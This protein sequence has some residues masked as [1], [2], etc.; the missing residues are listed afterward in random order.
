MDLTLRPSTLEAL[1]TVRARHNSLL[2]WRGVLIALCFVLCLLAVIAL[3][4]RAWL[5]PEKA[6]PW[7]SLAAYASCFVAAW[8][9][10]LRYLR[11]ETDQTGIARHAETLA[12]EVREKLLSAV[13]LAHGD[14]SKVKDSPEF[15][16]RLQ[17]E[18]EQ[19]VKGINWKVRQPATDLVPWWR[20]LLYA[21]LIAAALCFIPML[22]FPGFMARAALPF[23]NLERPSSVKITL[24]SPEKVRTLAP[25][26]SEV[27]VAVRIEGADVSSAEIEYGEAT[28]SP[29]RMELAKVTA[30]R[31]EA[32][33]PV[34]QT[35]VRFRVRAR[36]GL[37]GWYTLEA[38][39]RP[40]ITEFAKTVVA[41]SYAGLPDVETKA[42]HGDIEVLEGS[43]VKL[44][45][46]SNQPL[47]NAAL[48]LNPDHPTHPEAPPV[49][50]D[51]ARTILLTSLIV[52]GKAESWTT[53]LTAEETGFTNEESGAWRITSI[54]DLP[55]VVVLTEPVEAQISL[56]PDASLVIR[57]TASDD[58]GV[59]KVELMRQINGS[60]WQPAIL[61]EKPGRE[62]TV[63]H[64]LVLIP[65][66]L[67]PGDTLQA[68]LV[69][70]DLKG[71]TAESALLRIIV[72]EQTVDPR[73]RVWAAE[74]RR[75][76][77]MADELRERTSQLTKDSSTLQKTAKDEERGRTE[78][79]EAQTQL[80][81]MKQQLQRTVEQADEVWEQIKKTAREAPT[82][83]DA[84]ENRQLGQ[85]LAQVRQS[86][87][88]RLKELTSGNIESTDLIKRAASEANAAADAVA[89]A[90]KAF[91]AEES[92]RLGEQLARQHAR[93]QTRL[94]EQSLQAN[95][96]PAQR[97]K[98]QEQQRAA[99]SANDELMTELEDLKGQV[100][101]GHQNHL[102]QARKQIAEANRDLTESLDNPEDADK[103]KP[104]PDSVVPATKSP[105]HLYGAA[106]NLAQR[107]QRSS[108]AIHNMA[109]EAARRAAD[110][111]QKLM[112][113]DNPALVA[114]EQARQELEQAARE[115]AAP[116]K[117]P[118]PLKD[119]M[120]DAQ[121]AQQ[122]LADAARQLQAQAELREQNADTN[123]DA[124][125]DTNRTSR[126]AEEI[127]RETSEAGT[128]ATKLAAAKEKAVALSKLARTLDAEA[129]AQSARKALDQA[130]ANQAIAQN[131]PSSDA[132]QNATEAAQQAS[133][134]LRSLPQ[135]LRRT[136]L[137][138][139]N[140]A[141]PNVAQQAADQARAAAEELRNRARQLA[142]LQP[143]QTPPV[144]PPPGTLTEAQNRAA[145]IATAL[146]EE[147]RAAREQLATLAPKLS[148]M[149]KR[150]AGDLKQT[151]E[152]TADAADM[153]EQEK[154]VSEVAEQ[155]R[156]IQPDA[157]E[158]AR[159]MESLQAALRQEANAAILTEE[160]E[161]QLART[162]DVALEQM[163]QKSPQIEKNLESA[164][165]ASASKPQAE[166]LNAAA[167]AQQ[168]T[169]EALE[170]LAQ[171]FATM[172]A[173][174]QV[175]SESLAELA[176]M[177]QELGVQQPL[178]EAYDAA[179]RLAE[180]ARQANKDPAGALALLEAQLKSSP[181][182]QKALA[183][184]AATAAQEAEKKLADNANQPA[185]LGNAAEEA[186]HEAARVAR[187]QTR[188]A[189]LEAAK[190]IADASEKLNATAKATK[191]EPGNAT[192]QVA[193]AAQ[194]AAQ[195][196]S[197]TAKEEATATPETSDLSD[198]EA[199][200]AREL[201][202]ALDQLDQMLNP[203]GDP[204]SQQSQQ[205]GQQ[206]SAKAGEGDQQG[207]QESLA[208]AQ[209]KQQQAM[210]Q[211]RAEGKVPGEGQQDPQTAQNGKKPAPGDS[212]GSPTDD[213]GD[214]DALVKAEDG[215]LVPIQIVVD[216]DWGRLPAKMAED[217]T[218]A[219]RQEAPPEYRAAI[220]NYYKAISAKSRK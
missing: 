118:K 25:M 47:S 173:G 205:Q 34:G 185:F 157:A 43:T 139:R 162:A 172:E 156:A 204:Q 208:N 80:A 53:R 103:E 27:D 1:R 78:P 207:A 95:R 181:A 196:A 220:E 79:N 115:A 24:I 121:R 122:K 8:R 32:R 74:Q 62:T 132:P 73:Q 71:Q 120:T 155:T 21:M 193:Q 97:L 179:Q 212:D 17:D 30:E 85:R 36:D 101:G 11:P 61:K 134:Q 57:G 13:E 76:A 10:G 67:S 141:L 182:M 56:Q 44:S 26:V 64:T 133:E 143:G 87:L 200:Q 191:T 22:H 170:K 180:I 166:S 124:A 164:A 18:V 138:Q 81:R 45:L 137:G 113:A 117:K 88:P 128:D 110:M 99:I 77:Q 108:E 93:Q 203:L 187:H 68:K 104:A 102:E 89:S 106:D 197:R 63:E 15:R 131:Q 214:M 84:E 75:L 60:G 174:Q 140:N 94:K 189:K 177:E 38:R 50:L 219:T 146:A 55:P 116:P 209:Q 111:R 125:L 48:L 114:L 202:A 147:T 183:N 2:W 206:Q 176:A 160:N 159:K 14:A 16:A 171:N 70:T 59:A 217:L 96:D 169:S 150:V 213:G 215:T 129:L 105:E 52:D 19:V 119:G 82:A 188:L 184:L 6:R 100:N 192:P 28:A 54:P 86:A 58:V 175:S 126:A 69:A 145:E 5:M 135:A 190:K 51:A 163:R 186:G 161:R 41:P 218:E 35:D 210:A 168:M 31:F 158:N 3:L 211:A 98:W 194:D 127:A 142:Q 49:K 23:A 153:A 65:M 195:T 198:L 4:D 72:T 130:Q 216:G 112:Q 91:A 149:M 40:R 39:A 107:L 66:Q 136:E 178:D 33:L 37:T 42:D 109:E 83:A 201:A 12:P 92:L 154:P 151:Q 90:A 165:Q 167:D 152:K 7:V 144:L 9:L 20:R 123:T 46:K 199:A 148:E 29:R